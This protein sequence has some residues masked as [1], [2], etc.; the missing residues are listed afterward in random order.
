MFFGIVSSVQ[1]LGSCHVPFGVTDVT[2]LLRGAHFTL[3]INCPAT[4]GINMGVDSNCFVR[5]VFVIG[6]SLDAINLD[7]L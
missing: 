2:S 5:I 7:R 3:E 4:T 1:I 6:C